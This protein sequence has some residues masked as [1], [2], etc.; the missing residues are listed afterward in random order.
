MKL[1]ITISVKQCTEVCKTK[2]MAQLH[3]WKPATQNR[4]SNTTRGPEAVNSITNTFLCYYSCRQSFFQL[5]SRNHFPGH[6]QWH[7]AVIRDHVCVLTE[8][9]P[10][11]FSHLKVKTHS[12]QVPWHSAV[13]NT[14]GAD[15]EY[16]PFFFPFVE[17]TDEYKLLHYFSTPLTTLLLVLEVCVSKVNRET[18]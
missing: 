4:Y 9:V 2:A 6:F 3:L 18:T 10:L 11:N 5:F 16:W 12:W 8:N 13:L 17:F 7:E 14:A 1:K 15:T